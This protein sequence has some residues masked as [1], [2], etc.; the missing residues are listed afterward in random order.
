MKKTIMIA[1]C[2]LFS[3]AV[4]AGTEM[5]PSAAEYPPNAL[6]KLNTY[7]QSGITEFQ[8]PGVP[9]WGATE[10]RFGIGFWGTPIQ[11]GDTVEHP[12]AALISW[13]PG[14]WMVVDYLPPL[15][16]DNLGMYTGSD[17]GDLLEYKKFIAREFSPLITPY[18][19][20]VGVP[21]KANWEVIRS[22]I[23]RLTVTDTTITVE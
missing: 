19:I 4:S 18:M 12:Y 14:G 10:V 5:R 21:P 11:I 1:L 8:V 23:G 2:L 22:A 7:E 13:T 20:S 9:S 3:V 15:W 6:N 16:S 17:Y